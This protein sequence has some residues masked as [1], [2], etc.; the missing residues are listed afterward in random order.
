MGAGVGSVLAPSA[1]LSGLS[2]HN[3]SRASKPPAMPR[4]YYYLATLLHAGPRCER[5]SGLYSD[6]NPITYSFSKQSHFLNIFRD[7]DQITSSDSLFQYLTI[8]AMKKFLVYKLNQPWDSLRLCHLI[9]G[10]ETNLLLGIPSF[11]VLVKSDEAPFL[12][13]KHPQLLLSGL[14]LQTLPQLRCP[15]LDSLQPLSVFLALRVQIW[16]QHLRC[17]LSSAQDRGTIPALLLLATLLLTQAR[18]PLAFLATWAHPGS[19]SAAATSSPRSFPATL[20]QPVALPGIVVTQGQDPVLGL[21]EPHTFGLGHDPAW[22]DPSAEPS[23]PPAEQ[24]SHPIQC[25][26]Q[27]DRVFYPLI[28]IINKDIKQSWSHY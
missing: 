8:L 5:Q 24:H 12:Q 4:F 14:V 27:I 11:Q 9:L 25:H 3:L 22:P 21:V 10:E 2:L 26:L 16:T 1:A 6:L 19:C 15:S 18:M 28:H 7:G 20:S 17:G 13:D 23:W